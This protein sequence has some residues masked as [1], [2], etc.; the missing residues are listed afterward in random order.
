MSASQMKV[1]SSTFWDQGQQWSGKACACILLEYSPRRQQLPSTLSLVVS[2]GYLVKT[3]ISQNAIV[4]SKFP[5]SHQLR[6]QPSFPE[7]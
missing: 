6:G 5:G 1:W 4:I 2:D 7:P 3:G